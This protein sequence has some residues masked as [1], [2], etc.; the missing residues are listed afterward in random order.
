MKPTYLDKLVELFT[1]RPSEWFDG[2]AL[3]HVGGCYAWRTRVAEAR[4]KLQGEGLGT[5]INEQRRMPDGSK[6]SLYKFEYAKER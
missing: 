6:R 2:M 1:S 5:I 4:V 3:S